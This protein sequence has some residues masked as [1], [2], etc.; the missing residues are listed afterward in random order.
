MTETTVSIELK[1][2][3]KSLRARMSMSQKE[4]AERLGVSDKTL[5]SWEKDSSDLSLK[6]IEKIESVYCVPKDYIFFGTDHAFSEK[7]SRFS[8]EIQPA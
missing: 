6:Q 7:I 2:T 3:L 5:Q 8:R 1:Y 4:A